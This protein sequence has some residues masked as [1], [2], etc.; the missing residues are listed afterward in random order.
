MTLSDDESVV[1]SEYSDDDVY[2]VGKGSGL[3][4]IEGQPGM[5]YKVSACI[6]LLIF[7]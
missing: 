7:P 6:E 1:G 2:V 3:K 5:Y 4:A